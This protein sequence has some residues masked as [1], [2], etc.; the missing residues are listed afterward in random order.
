[1]GGIP[2]KGFASTALICGGRSAGGFGTVVLTGARST[3]DRDGPAD[4]GVGVAAPGVQDAA[5]AARAIS[6]ASLQAVADCRRPL[7]VA[8][9]RTCP[10]FEGRP[11]LLSVHVRM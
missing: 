8:F 3:D 6:P 10:D 2:G 5:S 11:E 9:L 1:M 4:A 7:V